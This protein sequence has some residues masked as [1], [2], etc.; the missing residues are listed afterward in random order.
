MCLARPVH[1]R[2]MHKPVE[3]STVQGLGKSDCKTKLC[4]RHI[5]ANS[6]IDR[7]AQPQIAVER[8]AVL[9]FR[10]SL[11]NPRLQSDAPRPCIAS[12]AFDS[13]TLRGMAV[14]VKLEDSE[15]SSLNRYR[16]TPTISYHSAYLLYFTLFC[17]LQ[18]LACSIICQ[19]AGLER[20]IGVSL[21]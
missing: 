10:P 11:P 13:I 7:S 12:L 21:D 16:E 9:D 17:A 1:A 8:F 14:S 6:S 3:K 20:V 15:I 4:T 2:R 18:L 19:G 5:L